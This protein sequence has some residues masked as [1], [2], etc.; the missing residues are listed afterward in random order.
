MQI[1]KLIIDRNSYRR[2][3]SPPTPKDSVLKQFTAANELVIQVGH[4]RLG[5]S[6]GEGGYG[7]V[8]EAWDDKLQRSVAIKRLKTAVAAGPGDLINEARHAAALN[9]GAFVKIFTFED[10]GRAQY[11]VMELIRG[12][13]LRLCLP[14]ISRRPDQVL[15]ITA[16]IAAAMAEAH[17]AGMVHGD[18]KP[19][20]LM[21]E[22]GGAVRILDF[23]LAR[24]ADPLATQSLDATAPLGT[25]A[26]MA[27]ERLTGS[28]LQPSSDIYALGVLLYEMT[29]GERPLASL[30]GLALAAAQLQTSS[31]QWPFPP[32]ASA[33]LVALIR[34]MTAREPQHRLASMAS[35]REHVL[36]LHAGVA[37]VLLPPPAPRGRQ[38]PAWRRIAAGLALASVLGLAG[39]WWLPGLERDW[40]RP[41]SE[42]SA[43]QAGLQALRL[44]DR[45]GELDVASAQFNRILAHDKHHAAATAGLSLTDSMR[46]IGDGR[47]ETWLKK[48]AAGAQ[49][50]LQANDQ[51]ALAHTAHAWV[52]ALQGREDA[53]L[54]AVERALQLDPADIPALN[55]KANI[56]LRLRRHD[57]AQQLIDDGARRFPGERL[58]AD[59]AGTLQFQRGDYAA[60]EQAFRR[61][62]RIEADAPQAY[63]NLSAALLRQN[64]GDEALQVLQQGLQ[65]RSSGLLY[66]NL[67]TALFARGDYDG[68]VRAF[69]HAV[70]ANKGG[71]HDYLRWANLA[72]ALR[73]LP[74]REQE[75]RQAYQRAMRLLAPILARQPDDPTYLTRM[76]VYAAHVGEA[77]AA[78]QADH[79]AS[80]APDNPD[81]HFRAAL[82]NELSGRRQAALVHLARAHAL[83]YPTTLIE[84]EPDFLA[85][86]RDSRYLSFTM[87]SSR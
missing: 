10:D 12:H 55:A 30:H 35:V 2:V 86:R 69:T 3:H 8:Y 77:G 85:L 73:W 46:Y 38:G 40:A 63:A 34:A 4:Y 64:K 47:D 87:E 53:A 41:Y 32:H 76:A 11:I 66:S 71:P 62:L 26:Y 54:A 74:G 79:G 67:G 27:P 61:S 72:D 15:H 37:Q 42:T 49:Q 36:H 22:P 7:H 52:L 24:Y 59:L 39:M 56:L 14:Q 28:P 83:G 65:V 57:A 43:M 50:A 1:L 51:L 45:A 5:K 81:A 78:D 29:T 80:L 6:L 23:G 84:S 82:A 19:S 20:N 48:A 75:A 21:L 60:A 25:I 33:P 70:S 44:A 31:D 18:L 9:H 13:T 58:F 17:A 68:A 16:Q